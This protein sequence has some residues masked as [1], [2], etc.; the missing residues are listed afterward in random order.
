MTISGPLLFDL[1][2]T[3]IDSL[4]DLTAAV[5]H[6]RSAFSHPPLAAD[7]VRT[8]VGRGA[9]NLIRQALPEPG[10]AS[11]EKALGLFLDYN[12]QHIADHSRPYPGITE[13]LETL[14][15]CGCRLAV[16]SNKNEDLSR[17]ILEALGIAG[18]FTLVCGGDTFSEMKP[19]PLPLLRV[20]ERLG[21]APGQGSMIGDSINDIQA[22]KRAGIATV[23]CQWGYGA[24][25]DL[26]Q[27]D[28]MI[29]SPN[30]ILALMAENV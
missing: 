2:G 24:A 23:G 20:I 28:F 6:M 16:I 25:H 27:A 4:D 15:D 7:T 22:G 12:R 10:I 17:T 5:N 29:S 18:H 19:S 14:T 8:M 30:E 3:L 21:T 9:R 26:E 13:L 1:D 11:Q